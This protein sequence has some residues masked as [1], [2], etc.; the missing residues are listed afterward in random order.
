MT[1]LNIAQMAKHGSNLDKDK[2]NFCRNMNNHTAFDWF[3]PKICKT[4]LPSVS[5]VLCV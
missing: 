3:G 4:A 5:S 1:H 2:D